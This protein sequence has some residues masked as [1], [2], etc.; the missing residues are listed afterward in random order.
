MHEGKPGRNFS[1][2]KLYDA[3][4]EEASQQ[5]EKNKFFI[6][7]VSFLKLCTFNSRLLGVCR[8]KHMWME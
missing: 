6:G 1:S 7:G 2:V 3:Q 8:K 4:E 5:E